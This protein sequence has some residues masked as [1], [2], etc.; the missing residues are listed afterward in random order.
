MQNRYVN[1]LRAL[2][3]F[4]LGPEQAGEIADPTPE[5]LTKFFE[6]RKRLFRA[7]EFRKVES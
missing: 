4:V 7:P 3:Y 1:E 6:E 5:E 2:D